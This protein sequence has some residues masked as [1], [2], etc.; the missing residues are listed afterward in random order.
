MSKIESRVVEHRG[1]STCSNKQQGNVGV[2]FMID[3]KRAF[4]FPLSIPAAKQ[5]IEDL[6]DS[7]RK[8]E[9]AAS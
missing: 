6:L 1:Y 4:I 3:E 9:D 7:I 5:L 8:V 2:S